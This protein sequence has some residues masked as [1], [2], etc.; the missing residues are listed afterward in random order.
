VFYRVDVRLE[1]RWLFGAQRYLAFVAE[2]MNVTGST[3]TF[4]DSVFGPVVIPSLGL[5]GGM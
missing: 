2:F 4:G 3:E 1:K 5:E